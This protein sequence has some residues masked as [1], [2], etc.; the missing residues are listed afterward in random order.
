M[1]R[2]L[3][4][5][6]APK[7]ASTWKASFRSRATRPRASSG[8]VAPVFTV[9]ALPMMQKGCRPARWSA[10][11]ARSKALTSMRKSASTVMRRSAEAPNPRTTKARA[12]ELCASWEV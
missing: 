1:V 12:T 2:R 4:P 10:A 8:S 3:S 5:S 9:P 6:H 7:A 11:M